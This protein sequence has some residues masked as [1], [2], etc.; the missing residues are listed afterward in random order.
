MSN[1][2]VKST[3]GKLGN[4]QVEVERLQRRAT[5]LT[6]IAVAMALA[7]GSVTAYGYLTLKKHDIAL[8]EL[9]G[10]AESLQ[11]ASE[12]LDE[13]E[14]KLHTWAAD[15]DRVEARLEEVDRKFAYN[16]AASRKQAREMVTQ[17]Q[18][19]LETEMGERAQAVDARLSSLETGQQAQRARLD[20][21][22]EE[23]GGVRRDTGGDLAALHSELARGERERGALARQH[24]RE[25]VDFEL[26]R[27]K[28][29]EL[30]PGVA[31]RITGTNVGRQQIK[32]W[33]WLMPDR[34]TLWVRELGLQQPLVFYHKDGGG[35]NELVITRVTKRG[36]IGY[37]LAP[38]AGG[39][40]ISKAAPDSQGNETAA[41]G[42]ANEATPALQ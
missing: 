21:V 9:P 33:M 27:N 40:S 19:R 5:I 14:Q 29:K 39:V 12:R 18:E 37:L 7:L 23:I 17:V 22:Q 2:F 10:L 32:G 25:R 31:L 15:W 6:A 20:Q 26:A 36:A 38:A 16:R 35:P 8:G 30:A 34:K 11:L 13:V 1:G 4:T 24:E 28:T 42:R 41:G 3:P